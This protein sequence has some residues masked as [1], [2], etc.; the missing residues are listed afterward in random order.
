MKN[1]KYKSD[2][3]LLN[4]K[5]IVYLDTA[6]TSQKPQCVIDAISEFYTEYNANPLRGLYELSSNATDIYEEARERCASF[7]NASS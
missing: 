1:N 5:N 6:A 3:P 2:F 7:I 4:N